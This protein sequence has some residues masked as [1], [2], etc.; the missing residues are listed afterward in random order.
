VDSQA[1]RGMAANKKG[2]RGVGNTGNTP[3]AIVLAFAWESPLL[4]MGAGVA[5]EGSRHDREPSLAMILGQAG[6]NLEGQLAAWP[7]EEGVR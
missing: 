6:E 2:I 7:L 4:M 5:G 3:V 1:L